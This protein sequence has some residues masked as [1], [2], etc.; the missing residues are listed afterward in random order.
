ML[1]VQ[2]TLAYPAAAQDAEL[3]EKLQAVLDNRV[4]LP[5]VVMEDVPPVPRLW[6][7][8]VEFSAFEPR[9]GG[10]Q[11]YIQHRAALSFDYLGDYVAGKENADIIVRQETQSLRV[12]APSG[13]GTT[14]S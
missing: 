13:A 11:R 9:N 12:R 10:V 3:L 4:V 8:S 2:E 5:Q 6:L 1:K 14:L 7:A